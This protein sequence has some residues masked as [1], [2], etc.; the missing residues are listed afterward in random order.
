MTVEYAPWT[1]VPAV[2]LH[3]IRNI[4]RKNLFAI[5]AS[6]LTPVALA[7]LYLLIIPPTY[8]A[9]TEILIDPRGLQVVQNDVTPRTDNNESSVSVVESQLR[10]VQSEAVLRAVINQLHLNDDPEFIGR[11]NW[12]SEIRGLFSF[13]AP[14][15]SRTTAL[16]SLQKAVVAQRASRSYVIVIKARSEDPIKA[17]RIADAV[18]TAYLDHEIKERA[19]TA[20]RVEAAI[21][22]RLK[23][24]ADRLHKSEEE[25]EA[26]R[27]QNNL[28]GTGKRL[29]NDQ[30]LEE[31][32]TRLGAARGQTAAQRARLSQVEVI[33]KS[34]AD[35]D[36]IPEAVLQSTAVA[37]LRSQYAEIMR[38]EGTASVLYGPLHPTVKIIREQRA[39]Y[40]A[41]IA[42]ELRRIADSTRNEYTRAKANEDALAAELET[43]KQKVVASDELSVRLRELERIAASNRAIYEAFLVRRKEIGEQGAIDTSNTRVIAAALAPNRP[44]S[45]RGSL[46]LLSLII[47]F[48]IAAGVVWVKSRASTTRSAS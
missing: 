26:F 47:G 33:L 17:A 18:A 3:G 5:C 29:V 39:R 30:Q 28:V 48:A 9:S 1:T 40:R 42:D 32:N 13:G 41:L 6:V 38:S 45:P 36:A 37:N 8:E 12:L 23:E 43:L 11:S 25:V 44:A 35:P 31:L 20:R 19:E 2:S 46:I 21:G 34:G 22:S 24:L 4:V 27:K 16:R 10:V 15:D 14:E 7:C